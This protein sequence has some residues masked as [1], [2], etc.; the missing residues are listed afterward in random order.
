MSNQ[1]AS[2]E[3]RH[4]GGQGEG[5][6]LALIHGWGLGSAAWA[7]VVELLAGRCREIGRA[8]V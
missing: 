8:H 3:N 7:P 6:D 2:Q 1:V 4:A 5:P